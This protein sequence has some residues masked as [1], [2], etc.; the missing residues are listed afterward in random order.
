LLE[1]KNSRF[2]Q[3]NI[4][5][6]GIPEGYVKKALAEE[7]LWM[8][9]ASGRA[10]FYLALINNEIVGFAQT[11]QSDSRTAELD[12][13]LVFPKHS[14]KGVG[15]QL[16]KQTLAD[17]KKKGIKKFIVKAGKAETHA[18]RFYE[19]NGFKRIKEAIVT[20]PWGKKL[21]LV[22]YEILLEPA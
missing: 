18:R 17:Q 8:A 7:K 5:K 3:E 11:E 4:I 19:K 22:I 12:R 14:R 10:D 9:V 1:N 20:A 21:D 13:I 16:L 15:T 2:Y 6:F